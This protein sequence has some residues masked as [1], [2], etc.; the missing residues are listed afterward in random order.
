VLIAIANAAKADVSPTQ[1]IDTSALVD[2]MPAIST[3]TLVASTHDVDIQ[4]ETEI[5][6]EQVLIRRPKRVMKRSAATGNDEGLTA[7]SKRAKR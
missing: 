3:P 2:A 1:D 7:G 6:T 5:A 4:P